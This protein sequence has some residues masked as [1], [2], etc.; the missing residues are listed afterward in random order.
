MKCPSLS[1]PR[2]PESIMKRHSIT[3]PLAAA[4]I[5]A[6]AGASFAQ[7]ASATE[8]KAE[9]PKKVDHAGGRHDQN[10]SR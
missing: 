6:W 8:T 2:Q 1:G 9:A 10:G 3:A 4:A 7:T 5:M